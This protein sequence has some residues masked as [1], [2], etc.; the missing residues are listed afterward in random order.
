LRLGLDDPSAAHNLAI[1]CISVKAGTRLTVGVSGLVRVRLRLRL[2]LRLRGR[3]RG[4]VR[5]RAKVRVGVKVRVGSG[6][7]IRA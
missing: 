6:S 2:R 7:G 4:R 1:T 5:L 3:A